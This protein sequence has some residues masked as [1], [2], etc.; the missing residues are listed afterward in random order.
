MRTKQH[1]EKLLNRNQGATIWFSLAAQAVYA[2]RQG[3]FDPNDDNYDDDLWRT[4]ALKL[5]RKYGENLTVEQVKSEMDSPAP[6]KL[7]PAILPATTHERLRSYAF[8]HNM[9]MAEIVRQAT[10][11]WLDK[12]GGVSEKS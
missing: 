9:S 5:K 6:M 8:E 12:K 3:S 7:F 10:A 1:Y 11:E 4:I 2:S